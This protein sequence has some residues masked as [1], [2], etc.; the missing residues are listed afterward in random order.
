VA[1]IVGYIRL[2]RRHIAL[3]VARV[4]AEVFVGTKLPGVDEDRDGDERRAGFANDFDEGEMTRVKIAHRRHE[5]YDRPLSPRLCNGFAAFLK[6]SDDDHGLSRRC[7]AEIT[8]R[9]E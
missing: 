5:T 4:G 9:T 7:P 6:R 1:A 8:R 2:Q 3:F